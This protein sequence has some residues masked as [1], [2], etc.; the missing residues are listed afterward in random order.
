M[1]IP[2]ELAKAERL[3]AAGKLEEAKEVVKGVLG[4][5]KRNAQAWYLVN[6]CITD[7][8]AKAESLRRALLSDPNHVKAKREFE[9]MNGLDIL[10]P[11]SMSVPATPPAKANTRPLLLPVAGVLVLVVVVVGIVAFASTRTQP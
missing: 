8:R 7:P 1:N 3:I 6:Q 4:E 9:A 2:T 10:K 5:D 11:P